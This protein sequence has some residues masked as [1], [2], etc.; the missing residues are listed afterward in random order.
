MECQIPSQSKTASGIK[1]L[2]Q[3]SQGLKNIKYKEVLSRISTFKLLFSHIEKGLKRA[4]FLF[5]H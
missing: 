2:S 1:V 4:K 3:G 5:I